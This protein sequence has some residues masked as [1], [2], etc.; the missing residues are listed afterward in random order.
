MTADLATTHGLPVP[1]EMAVRRLFASLLDK[2]YEQA[3]LYTYTD[4]AG[5]PLFYKVRF[6]PP[7]GSKLRKEFRA[8]HSN[9][10]E[11]LPREPAFPDGKPLYRLHEL[12]RGGVVLFVEGEKK[13]D[14]LAGL[15]LPAT[16]AGGAQSDEKTDFRPLAGRHVRLWPDNDEPGKAHMLRV[17]ARLHA[18]G[19]STSVI[20]V[21][22]LGLGPK[23]DA[24]DWLAA[25]PNAT[26][27]DVLALPVEADAN[28]ITGPIPGASATPDADVG[29]A[30]LG[31]VEDY[32]GRFVAYPSEHD[33]VAHVLWIAHAHLMDVWSSTPRLAFL[34]P[35]PGSG[36]SRALE[37]TE[38]LT[39]R[40]VQTISVSAPYIFRKIAD[41]NGSPTVLFDEVDTIFGP[42][43]KGDNEDIRGLINA[44]HRRGAMVG[45]CAVR[46][47]QI[48]T[49]EMPSYC[50]VAMAGLG[51]LPD[52]ILTR[53]VVIKMRR[54]SPSEIVEPFRPRLHEGAGHALRDRLEAWA[55]MVRPQVT[56]A[57]PSLPD[58]VV[59]R[60]ADV[61][62]PLITVAD[63]AGGDWP[64]RSRDAAIALVAAS[65]STTPSLGIRLL[66]DL[67]AVFGQ[68]EAM[69]TEEIISALRA[70][71][72]APWGDLKGKP[73]DPR[74]LARRLKPYGV[75]SKNVRTPSSAGPVKGY[76]RVDFHDAWER[77]CP[78]SLSPCT[79][80]TSATNAESRANPS[81]LVAARS[82]CD[83]FVAARSGCGDPE[84]RSGRSGRSGWAEQADGRREWRISGFSEHPVAA[85]AD[86]ALP[87]GERDAV[88]P[89][90]PAADDEEGISWAD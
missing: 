79:S 27:A 16:T 9:G 31:S 6:S 75:T 84:S 8:F 83:D 82:G 74:G 59:D 11:W 68:R 65:R 36:K 33:R 86:V 57:W 53:S 18:L 19:C 72:E 28:G 55:L 23:G 4:A 80:A 51:D 5:S 20:D 89:A 73:I 60:A 39:P 70:L 17:A 35:E 43:V 34:S 32:I 69:S 24:V 40:P 1:P 3:G 38:P 12:A 64:R 22:R 58:G 85:V 52:T 13:A 76:G 54:R 90:T 14:E 87:G 25:H 81:D 61:W 29:A 71:D 48:F 10:I 49:E 37:V 67:R 45:R 30:L 44:G 26:A 7:E 42:N 63:A 62:E 2:G 66:A 88:D 78:V 50:A 21:E 15:D 41:E 47:K 46:G 77:Y 56:N